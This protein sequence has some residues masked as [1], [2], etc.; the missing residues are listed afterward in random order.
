MVAMPRHCGRYGTNTGNGDA[1]TVRDPTQRLK[2]GWA[3]YLYN[4]GG[5]LYSSINYAAGAGMDDFESQWFAG[6]NGDAQEGGAA[7][8]GKSLLLR[9]STLIAST[10]PNP[11]TRRKNC[12]HKHKTSPHKKHI[13]QMLKF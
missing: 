10:T 1:G 9:G 13:A 4:V 6:G 5:E 12:I 3:T 7:A 8:S 2:H 11:R